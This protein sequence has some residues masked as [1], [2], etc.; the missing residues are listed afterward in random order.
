MAKMSDV[1]KLA[2]VSTA[3]VSRVLRKPETVKKAT[4]EKVFYAIQQL[5]YQP[6]MLARHF[7]TNKTKSI[8]VVVPS[9]TNLVFAA[10]IDGIDEVA[11][12]AGYQVIFGNTKQ[13][14]GKAREYVAHLKQKQVDGIILMTVRLEQEAWAEIANRYPIVLASDALVGLKVPTVSTTNIEGAYEAV[15]HLIQLGHKKIAHVAGLPEI[16]VS[17]ERAK[18]Y[19]LALEENGIT[20]DPAL[21]LEGEYS[22]EVGRKSMKKLMSQSPKPT[23]VFFG[24]DEM[25][26]GGIKA[27]KE[28]GMRV[29]EDVAVIGFDDIKFA[30]VMDPPLTTVA[31]PLHEMGKKAMEILLTLMNGQKT[32]Q[33]VYT[34][35]SEFKI[36]DSCGAYL[37]N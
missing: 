15:C 8:M 25:A 1:A 16:A 21:Y 23:A 22:I 14:T 30:E 19:R 27:A 35:K 13:N 3:T 4:Q 28:L 11:T 7:R 9:L 31:Q 20:F 5:D 6:N 17:R 36:R 32:D 37:K 26:I 12:A 33:D 24:N 29:P 34:I 10:M 2:N 18:G